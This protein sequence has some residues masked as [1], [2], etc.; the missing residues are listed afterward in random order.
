MSSSQKTSFSDAGAAC[1]GAGSSSG[2]SLC[3]SK[4]IELTLND[5]INNKKYI[6]CRSWAEGRKEH[7]CP[8]DR[9]PDKLYHPFIR[10]RNNKKIEMRICRTWYNRGYCTN[11]SC[12]YQHPRELENKYAMYTNLCQGYHAKK[13]YET[14]IFGFKA[15][16]QDVPSGCKR[17]VCFH[18]HDHKQVALPQVEAFANTVWSE[19]NI[20]KLEEAFN[21]LFSNN[22]EMIRRY[23]NGTH[24]VVLERN[25]YEDMDLK[26]KMNMWEEI[27]CWYGNIEKGRVIENMCGYTQSS[28]PKKRWILDL[29]DFKYDEEWVWQLCRN[30]KICK[31]YQ[32]MLLKIFSGQKLIDKD[33]CVGGMY[34]KNG[35]HNPEHLISLDN[36]K[37]GVEDNH[38]EIEAQRDIIKATIEDLKEKIPLLPETKTEKVK[39]KAVF[40]GVKSQGSVVT[41]PRQE[42]IQKLG[43]HYMTLWTTKPHICPTKLGCKSIKCMQIEILKKKTRKNRDDTS[44]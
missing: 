33:I 24:F 29:S 6:V 1:S 12:F 38:D 16:F 42:A 4:T 30:T 26:S 22:I 11:S 40:K 17:G 13:L 31:T 2:V 34:C 41:Y 32:I 20:L 43:E 9:C 36:L 27:S 3:K 25:F 39:I 7:M 15:L 44:M 19:V 8:S 28:L 37:E 14:G 23:W 35:V 10:P 5:G 21:K 18:C